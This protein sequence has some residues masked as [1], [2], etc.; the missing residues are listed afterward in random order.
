MHESPL[1]ERPP[2]PAEQANSDTIPPMAGPMASV[3]SRWP[4]RIPRTLKGISPTRISTVI[5][6]HFPGARCTPRLSPAP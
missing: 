4:S 6:I 3:L 1:A 5:V 2:H